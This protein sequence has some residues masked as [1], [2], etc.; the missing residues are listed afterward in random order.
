MFLPRAKNIYLLQ[1]IQTGLCRSPAEF[2]LCSPQGRKIINFS[3][4]PKPAFAEVQ[5]NSGYVPDKGERYL[6][7]P[8]Y[9]NRPLRK[10]SGIM[11]MFRQGRKI[12]NFSKIPKL[13]FAEVQRKSGYVPPKSE[14]Y[15]SSPKYPNRPLKKPSGILVMFLTSAKD[16]Y[17]LQSIQTGL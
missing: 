7:Y 10:S 15:L 8:N 1:N 2:W 3:K 12:I 13:A 9:P 6:S 4:I 17:L 11:V 16:I 14:R 5:R